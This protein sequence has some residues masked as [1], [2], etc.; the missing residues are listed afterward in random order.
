MQGNPNPAG[1]DFKPTCFGQVT[2]SYERESLTAGGQGQ[3]FQTAQQ[4]GPAG[5]FSPVLRKQVE[6]ADMLVTT[7]AP[8]WEEPPQ[9]RILLLT[10]SL[11]L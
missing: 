3:T 5:P 9:G 4:K 2:S 10:V 7:H 6:R 8:L 11:G 1:P